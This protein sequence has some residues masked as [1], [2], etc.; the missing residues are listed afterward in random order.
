MVIEALISWFKRRFQFSEIDNSARMR[1]D[2][3]GNFQSHHK[4][5]P[6]QATTFMPLWDVRQAVSGFEGE[7]FK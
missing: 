2:F 7:I 6:V 3:P 1:I 5:M 4:G